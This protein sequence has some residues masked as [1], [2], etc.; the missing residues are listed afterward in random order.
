[1]LFPCD[2]ERAFGKIEELCLHALMSQLLTMLSVFIQ[3]KLITGVIVC[4]IVSLPTSIMEQF[5][6]WLFEDWNSVARKSS[7]S[8]ADMPTEFPMA[9]EGLGSSDC[10]EV[11]H[12]Q[13]F[14]WSYSELSIHVNITRGIEVCNN[15]L[16]GTI[17]PL[18]QCAQVLCWQMFLENI[19]K[20]T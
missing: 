16:K 9:L 18:G 10:G 4:H 3:A 12:I 17:Y 8:G 11:K 19:F 14:F 15:M 5:H 20:E 2:T 1:M 7:H 6:T 13:V